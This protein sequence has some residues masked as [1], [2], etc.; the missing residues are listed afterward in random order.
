MQ[1]YSDGVLIADATDS[2]IEVELPG[3]YMCKATNQIGSVDSST[4]TVAIVSR[5]GELCAI[6]AM[7]HLDHL[8]L[9]T[10]L[11][12]LQLMRCRYVHVRTLTLI[13]FP[14]APENIQAEGPAAVERYYQENIYQAPPEIEDQGLLAREAFYHALKEGGGMLFK[15]SRLLVVGQDRVGKTTWV[16][17]TVDG[18]NPSSDVPSS[19][20]GIAFTLVKVNLADPECKFEVPD[21][22]NEMELIERAQAMFIAKKVHEMDVNRRDKG[23]KKKEAAP[24]QQTVQAGEIKKEEEHPLDPKLPEPELHAEIHE[25][26]SGELSPN[27]MK[28]VNEELK[29]LR[30]GG[31]ETGADST[32]DS[33]LILRISDFA[34]QP[35]YYN[36][37]VFFL[38]DTGVYVIIFDLTKKLNDIAKVLVCHEGNETVVDNT[39][40]DT[41]IDYLKTWM[42]SIANTKQASQVNKATKQQA[43]QVDKA[44]TPE[45]DEAAKQ[46]ASQVDKVT[47][48]EVDEVAKKQTSQVTNQPV[49][50]L[51][52]SVLFI[53]SKVDKLDQGH[54]TISGFVTDIMDHQQTILRELTGSRDGVSTRSDATEEKLVSPSEEEKFRR[55][56]AHIRSPMFFV[57][58]HQKFSRSEREF[59]EIRKKIAE[60]AME[61]EATVRLMPFSWILFELELYEKKKTCRHLSKA[62]Y[63]ELACKHNIRPEDIEEVLI[64]FDKLGIVVYRPSSLLLSNT[65][66]IDTDWL[67]KV[68]RSIIRIRHPLQTPDDKDR[69]NDVSQTGI[70]SFSLLAKVLADEGLIKLGTDH[71]E[72]AF[73]TQLL[74][75]FNLLVPYIQAY[76][77][78]AQYRDKTDSLQVPQFL[79]P[80]LVKNNPHWEL[81]VPKEE[82]NPSTAQ[83]KPLFIRSLTG[84]I[85]DALYNQLVT[86]SISQ[87]PVCPE[88]YRYFS[89][90]HIDDR[91]DLLLFNCKPCGNGGRLS[92]ELSEALGTV[93]ITV[94]DS[95]AQCDA[96]VKSVCKKVLPRVLWALN[97]IKSTGLNG[98]QF[99]LETSVRVGYPPSWTFHRLSRA[100]K[101]HQIE[102]C[103]SVDCFDELSIYVHRANEELEKP[104]AEAH[105]TWIFKDCLLQVDTVL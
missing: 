17:A 23:D 39:G 16:E 95:Q 79:A 25:A 3:Y 55:N 46:Q 52:P 101:R 38:S 103:A 83:V 33:Y 105:G 104:L 6:V 91:Y 9:T 8:K 35:M 4:V 51:S 69:W 73:I 34:G 98:L 10:I 97:D 28:L 30:S 100:C 29:K 57:D 13:E 80:S 96:N 45:V 81:F 66:I 61:Q 77:L 70:I 19:T 20:D 2:K 84:S 67:M 58:S 74:Q 31:T 22:R 5:E 47:T 89:R 75:K 14:L 41:N 11:I 71:D 48:P 92:H 27:M 37:H 40:F 76:S 82:I 88:V 43:S 90:I 44:T 94:L 36:S 42:A 87:Y 64:Y 102:G 1:W 63:V 99:A 53:G 68:F 60:L 65:L 21:A 32:S 18:K 54:S 62:E 56:A 72:L 24:P 86:T 50:P 49:A 15:Q 7:P 12:M 78:V 59:I 93:M 85:P 26:F